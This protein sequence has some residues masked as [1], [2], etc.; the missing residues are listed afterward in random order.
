VI[1]I[2][3]LGSIANTFDGNPSWPLCGRVSEKTQEES[4]WK[5][6]DNCP[7]ERIGSPLHSDFPLSSTFGARQLVSDSYRYDFHRGID[8]PTPT[9]TPIFA[10]ADGIVKKAG[11]NRGYSDPVIVL[12]HFPEGYASTN[13]RKIGGCYHS[14]Y[15]HM[16][17]INIS[18]N[19]VVKKGDLIGY[20]GA[21]GS[22]FEHLH[23]EVRKA[24]SDDPY[25]SWQRDAI[26]PLSLLPYAN[27][28]ENNMSII[29]EEA[30]QIATQLQ[31]TVILSIPM[32][33]LD[34]SSI[35]AKIYD[36]Q[37]GDLI[38]QPDNTANSG[39]FHITPA[40]YNLT[41]ANRE[42]THKNSSSVTWGSFGS[43]GKRECPYHA[44]HKISY[45][46]N[47]HMDKASEYNHQVGSF[48][49]LLIAPNHYNANSNE[50]LTRYTFSHLIGAS[51]G[52]GESC[53][54]IEAT[55][56]QGTVSTATH[57]CTNE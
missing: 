57:N 40:L 52:I 38:S 1:F 3:P 50:Y 24:Q 33:E 12:R 35:E 47:I 56:V 30:S 29:V 41:V 9:G 39:G 10:I 45:E 23:F 21:S 16:S 5:A 19:T 31:V 32:S 49:G 44:E 36:N 43:G 27:K 2:L 26:H 48:N 4:G 6:G 51:G 7:I 37:T 53:I 28:S 18:E 34:L 8:I 42:Y 25:S 11:A 46:A 54:I 20:S 15:L 13:C 55:D 22:G 14:L 17:A